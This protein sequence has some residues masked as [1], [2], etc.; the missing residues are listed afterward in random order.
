[1][2][3]PRGGSTLSRWPTDHD[4]S[5]D[6]PP[7]NQQTSDG[8]HAA[9]Y[10]LFAVALVALVILGGVFQTLL[11]LALGL[12][13][14]ELICV[15]GPAW[16]FRRTRPELVEAFDPTLRRL[17]LPWWGLPVCML[18][19]AGLGV[20]AMLLS[21]LLVELI[22]QLQPI[23]E[24][25]RQSTSELLNP[26]STLERVGAAIAVAVAAPIGEEY[27]FRGTILPAQR[28][29][30][31][32]VM[33]VVMNGLLF[34]AVHLNPMTFVPLSI[35][36]MYLAHLTL[37]SGSLWP[38]IVGHATVN[39]LNGVILPLLFPELLEADQ[40]QQPAEIA[41]LLLAMALVFP[42]AL[43]AWAATIAGARRT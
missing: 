20:G 25:Y 23:A 42:L 30:E 34:G 24:A 22:P 28:R 10:L 21:A 4:V 6:D 38:A 33:A 9:P 41:E 27:L 2:R 40:P 37:T 7:S 8:Q 12:I 39:G 5:P 32:L 15:M 19:A 36:G 31:P 11:P 3:R 35:L 13:L 17:G 16:L 26:S 29:R 43:A 14:T 1:M 18:A